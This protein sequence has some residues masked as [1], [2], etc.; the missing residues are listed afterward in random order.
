MDGLSKKRQEVTRSD[1]KRHKAS[2]G[3]YKQYNAF[4][5]MLHSKIDHIL[6]V[7]VFLFQ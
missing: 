4:L 2:K 5:C 7:Q 6:H 1:K 3:F